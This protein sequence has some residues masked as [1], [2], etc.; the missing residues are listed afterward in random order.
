M[1]HVHLIVSGNGHAGS[2]M[3]TTCHSTF[4]IDFA[5]III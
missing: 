2:Y 5:L 4:A 3:N 1:E